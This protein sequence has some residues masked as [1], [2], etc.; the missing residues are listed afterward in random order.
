MKRFKYSPVAALLFFSGC[1]AAQPLSKLNPALEYSRKIRGIG[2]QTA[3]PFRSPS[4]QTAVPREDTVARLAVDRGQA[5]VRFVDGEWN[6]GTHRRA[7]EAGVVSNEL[8]DAQSPQEG[9]SEYRASMTDS[10]PYTG[11]LSLGDPGVTSSLWGESRGDNDMFRDHRAFQ[12]MDLITI[13]VSESAEGE[14]EADTET[15]SSSSVSASI[16]DMLGL[17]KY[18]TQANRNIELES[19]IAADTTNDFKGEGS[20][21]RKDSLVARIS[22]MVVEVLPSGILRIEGEKI[23]A[24]NNEEQVMVISG[25]VRTRDIN[26]ENEVNSAKVA[27]MRI[28]YYGKG[29]VGEAQYGG[30]LGR[31]LR[32]IWPF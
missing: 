21:S 17:E 22:A 4:A 26:S 2:A 20:T 27:N 24:V 8:T 14:K 28:D 12:P 23:I 18:I 11:P 9:F 10:A 1:M 25:L 3:A 5:Q 7:T 31:A 29:T 16:R 13:L 6:P 32:I 19:I 15:K 30:W